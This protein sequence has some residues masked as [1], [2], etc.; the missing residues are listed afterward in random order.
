MLKDEVDRRLRELDAQEKQER[1][2]ALHGVVEENC[3]LVCA[4]AFFG[5]FSL[6]VFL[7]RD[8]HTISLS[9]ADE[10]RRAE[11]ERRHQEMLQELAEV[12]RE[13][14][15]REMNEDMTLGISASNPLRFRPDHFKGLLPDQ[16]EAIKAKQREQIE[17]ARVCLFLSHFP[18]LEIC[19]LPFV[20]IFLYSHSAPTRGRGTAAEGGRAEGGCDR[21]DA[22]RPRAKSRTRPEGAGTAGYGREQAAGGDGTRAEEGA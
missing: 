19:C 2:D 3:R 5:S 14:K 11:A 8:S 16:V 17:E 21:A 20:A 12:E 10:K 13:M 1:K 18:S 9:Q 6:W 7:F 22:C 4:L 15:S